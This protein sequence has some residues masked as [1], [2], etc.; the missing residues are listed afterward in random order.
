MIL[1]NAYNTPSIPLYTNTPKA[2][3][4]E[5]TAD[6]IYMCWEESI[7]A[8]QHIEKVV[9]ALGVTTVGFALGVWTARAGLTYV[10]L[11]SYTY[12]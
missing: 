1:F 7:T 3:I 9:T 10:P 8:T 11:H 4:D 2:K 5:A 12:E 6:T